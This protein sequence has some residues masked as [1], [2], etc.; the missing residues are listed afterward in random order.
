MTL[1]NVPIAQKILFLCLGFVVGLALITAISSWGLIRIE[2]A[3]DEL[4]VATEEV[5]L[6]A[7]LTKDVLDLNRN[8]YHLALNPSAYDRL[9]PEIEADRDDFQNRLSQALSL[10]HSDDRAYLMAIQSS[11]ERY[12]QDLEHTL[13]QIRTHRD[14]E[15]SADQHALLESVDHSSETQRALRENIQRFVDHMEEEGVE[16]NHQAHTLVN[17]VQGVAIAIGLAIAAGGLWAGMAL[18][19]RQITKPLGTVVRNLQAVAEGELN[20]QIDNR[21]RRDEVG[22]LNRALAVFLENA[23]ARQIR[24]EQEQQDALRAAKRAETLHALTATFDHQITEALASLSSASEE[25]EATATAMSSSAE[26]TSA[27]TQSVSSSTT[28]TSANVQTVASSTEELSAAIA[29]VSSQIARSA[30]I[31]LTANQKT[32]HTLR[33]M[34]HLTGASGEIESVLNLVAQITNQTKLLALNATIEAAR[35]GEAGKGFGVVANEVKALAEETEKATLTVSEHVRAIQ[36]STR[37]VVESVKD[38]DHVVSEVNEVSSAV[39]TSA[40][41]QVAATDE[42]SR[43][44]SEAAHGTLEVSKSVEMIQTAATATAAAAAQVTHTAQELARQSVN[45][46]ESIQTYLTSVDAA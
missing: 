4:T 3:T 33:L 19:K 22:A 35:A 34:D 46:R 20:V 2:H 9:N 45:I 36:E 18:S 14:L 12:S 27:Q 40:H 31:S 6:G 38:I 29:E 24:L 21:E 1:S 7:Y 44:V 23:K 15:L 13:E 43:N 28:Q 26:E 16:V 39:A 5:R 41:Q 32:E 11:Y 8:E 42:I 37:V 10:A 25:L 30:K 17:E